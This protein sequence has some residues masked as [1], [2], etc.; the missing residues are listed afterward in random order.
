MFVACHDVLF[1]FKKTEL[2]L[3][4]SDGRATKTSGLAVDTVVQLELF[5]PHW[6]SHFTEGCREACLALHGKV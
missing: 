4:G 6:N 5:L 3:P 1:D 2:L